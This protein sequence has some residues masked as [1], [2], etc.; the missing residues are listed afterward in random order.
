MTW[1]QRH[2]LYGTLPLC[3][4]MPVAAT[5]YLDR[6]RGVLRGCSG[7]V[8]G[9]THDARTPSPSKQEGEVC[10][11]GRRK[12]L[13]QGMGNDCVL[14]VAP[15]R[16]VWH[17]D[18]RRKYPKLKVSRRQLPLC[19]YLAITAHA[20]QGLTMREGAIASSHDDNRV[21]AS[22]ASQVG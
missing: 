22:L 4:G 13:A 6:A 20:G 12:W 11:T 18:H 10:K 15:V 5:D 19:P 7:R 16:S 1:L 3:I 17:L 21:H 14:P 8:C 9:W 2:D